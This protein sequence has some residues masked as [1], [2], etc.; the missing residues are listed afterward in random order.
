[1]KFLRALNKTLKFDLQKD[2]HDSFGPSR[3]IAAQYFLKKHWAKQIRFL[4]MEWANYVAEK[5]EG[6]LFPAEIRVVGSYTDRLLKIPRLQRFPVP[7]SAF[8]FPFPFPDSPFLV[9]K[10]AAVFM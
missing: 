10:I 3:R 1:M 7:R 9:I 2:D 5:N 4:L 6:I 8:P